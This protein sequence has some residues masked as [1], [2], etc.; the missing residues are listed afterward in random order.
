MDDKP[1]Y[2]FQKVNPE[3]G[4]INAVHNQFDL[5]RLSF[6]INQD[7]CRA[8]YDYDVINY[9]INFQN[10]SVFDQILRFSNLTLQNSFFLFAFRHR[11]RLC[12]FRKLCLKL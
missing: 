8:Q 3:E 10:F 6:V 11:E 2:H 12:K 7:I 9:V 5:I 4:E 1:E